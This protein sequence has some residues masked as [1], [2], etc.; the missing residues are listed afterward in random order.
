MLEA[1]LDSCTPKQLGVQDA[2]PISSHSDIA[3]CAA[4]TA[5]AVGAS[6]G[7]LVG[8]AKRLVDVLPTRKQL[9]ALQENDV[10]TKAL[11]QWIIEGK[12][13]QDVPDLPRAW[14]KE[15]RY[16]H[17]HDGVL[18]HRPCSIRTKI[19]STCP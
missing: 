4:T 12:R 17:L 7:E 5:S 18:F 2:G 6:D 1:V 11:R 16:L 15:A 10:E 9:A 8:A 13:P 14:R 19:S 3:R